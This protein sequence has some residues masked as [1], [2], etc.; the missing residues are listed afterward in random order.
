M[1]RLNDKGA[2]SEF[3]EMIIVLIGF[4]VITI[5]AI[6]MV[7]KARIDVEGAVE[8]E[9]A[10]F[11]CKHDAFMFLQYKSSTGMPF[12]ELAVSSYATKDWTTFKREAEALFDGLLG[13][14]RWSMEVLSS[15]ESLA[16]LGAVSGKKEACG[17][18][19]PIPCQEEDACRIRLNL[20]VAY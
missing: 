12:D 5:I 16:K 8:A 13:S 9:N 2:F 1:R 6:F 10:Q 20:R 7:G 18:Y 15:E 4:F 3:G 17:V 14:G 19:V 11:T